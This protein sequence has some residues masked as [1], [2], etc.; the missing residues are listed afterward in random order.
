[1][2]PLPLKPQRVRLPAHPGLSFEKRQFLPHILKIFGALEIAPEPSRLEESLTLRTRHISFAEEVAI[3]ELH[4]LPHPQVRR[5]YTDVGE[6]R[7][8]ERL[9]Q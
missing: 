3:K 9:R 2:A 4:Q 6:G 8:T 5:L 1:M 7:K